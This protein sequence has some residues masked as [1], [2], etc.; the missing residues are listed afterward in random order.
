MTKRVAQ[1]L[2]KK[3]ENVMPIVIKLITDPQLKY[4]KDKFPLPQ[5]DEEVEDLLKWDST[6]PMYQIER[7]KYIRINILIIYFNRKKI[8]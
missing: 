3:L 6:L 2:G 8:K 5:K 7:Y 1:P 4:I